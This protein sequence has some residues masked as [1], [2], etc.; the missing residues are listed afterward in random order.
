MWDYDWTMKEIITSK[1]QII[2]CHHLNDQV[3]YNNKNF[4]LMKHYIYNPHHCNPLIFKN[5]YVVRDID[6]LLAGVYKPKHYPFKYRL[7]N[8][9]NKYKDTRLKKYNIHHLK[10]PGYNH[11]DAYTSRIQKDFSNH[12]NRTKICM[13]C[14]SKYKYRLGKYIEVPMCGAVIM[15]DVPYEDPLF[16]TFVIDINPNMSDTEIVNIL[17][18]HLE[19]PILLK[20]KAYKGEQWARSYTTEKYTDRFI[21]I[22]QN[23]KNNCE[24]KYD[25]VIAKV[26]NKTKKYYNLVAQT[27]KI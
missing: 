23:I 27:N 24:I 21:D 14:T 16:K 19:K 11:P 6:I 5:N 8:L 18:E 7:F 10:H 22:L 12:L 26:M 3:K 25:G 15:G 1:S 4:D 20:V 2:I 13:S 9:I 17:I